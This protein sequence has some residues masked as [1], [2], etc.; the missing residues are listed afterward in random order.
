MGWIPTRSV[1][2]E[3]ALFLEWP[4]ASFNIARGIAP[5]AEKHGPVLANGQIQFKACGLMLAVGQLISLRSRSLGR[6][7]RLR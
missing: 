4:T 1:T 3:V 2:L 7:P 5:G 6:Y